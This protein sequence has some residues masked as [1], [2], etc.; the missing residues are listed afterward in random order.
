MTD[1]TIG[2][3]RRSGKLRC[4]QNG[5]TSKQNDGVSNS[6]CDTPSVEEGRTHV[7]RIVADAK[8]LARVGLPDWVTSTEPRHACP[9]A[10]V[11]NAAMSDCEVP[12]NPYSQ[13]LD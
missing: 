7:L 3:F 9:V 2:R 12:V 5:K 1:T 6:Q 10:P 13:C 11:N 4:S 8:F